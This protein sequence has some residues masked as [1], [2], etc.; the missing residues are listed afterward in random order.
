MAAAAADDL[1]DLEEYLSTLENYIG[2]YLLFL[3]N[4]MFFKKMG[5]L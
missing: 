2:K 4:F 5:R 1:S 3:F